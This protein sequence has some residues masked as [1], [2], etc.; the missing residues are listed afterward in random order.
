MS[1]LKT[2]AANKAYMYYNY[3]DE[4]K[5]RITSVMNNI[6]DLTDISAN[7][8]SYSLNGEQ[9]DFIVAAFPI[10]LP[11]YNNI[12]DGT[13]FEELLNGAYRNWSHALNKLYRI[14]IETSSPEK[15]ALYKIC[16]HL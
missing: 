8:K 14:L 4:S 1:F 16:I 11:E 10:T 2:N 7:K 15:L 3:D 9:L 6:L 5:Y 12:G 13:R